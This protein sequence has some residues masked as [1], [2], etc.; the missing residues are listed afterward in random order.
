MWTRAHDV[1]YASVSDTFRYYLCEACD[2]LSIHPL[3][4]GRLDE[5]YPPTYYSFVGAGEPVERRGPITA[6]KAALD[7]RQ[8][9]RVSSLVRGDELRLLDVGGGSG[10]IS[11]RLVEASGGRAEAT[12]VD[13]DPASIEAARARGLRGEVARFEDFE[14]SERFHIVLMLNL[15]EHVANPIEVLVKARQL[16]VPGGVAWIQ[17]PNFR[18]FDARLFRDRC[19]TGLH[20]PRHW[21]VFSTS[22]LESAIRRAGLE[23]RVIEHTQAGSFWASSLLALRRSRRPPETGLRPLVQS[24][25]F[26]PLAAAGAGFDLATRRL[27][28]TSQVVAV[29]AAAN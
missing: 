7:R 17:T 27:R 14:T 2:A 24:P 1:E 10:A 12:V 20:C 23:P 18:A 26:L 25:L 13:I 5:I 11:A 8:F 3:P 22:G 29:A 9:A 19:W 21:V 4:A 6:V 15:I 16:L 28:A